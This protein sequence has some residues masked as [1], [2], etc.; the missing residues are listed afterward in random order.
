MLSS[1]GN[2]VPLQRGQSVPQPKPESVTLTTAPNTIK[3]KV[4]A[5]VE[6]DKMTNEDRRAALAFCSIIARVFVGSKLDRDTLSRFLLHC[7]V[8]II[9]KLRDM[10]LGEGDFVVQRRRVFGLK[11]VADLDSCSHNALL[12]RIY[13]HIAHAQ[14][15]SIAGHRLGRA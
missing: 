14:I 3:P 4:S 12:S 6:R 1:G 8:G 11:L 15:R 13:R 9:S 5:A 2:T 7:K 10:V